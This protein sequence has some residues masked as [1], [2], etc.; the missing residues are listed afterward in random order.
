MYYDVKTGLK[1]GK[2]TV[3]EA[4]GQKVT[5]TISYADYKDVKG[6]KI[7]YKTTMSLGP[8]EIEFVASEV[9]INEG[10]TDADFQ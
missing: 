3:Q 6:I 4:G 7:P 2:S 1:L 10:V 8:Q 9:K 5:Q